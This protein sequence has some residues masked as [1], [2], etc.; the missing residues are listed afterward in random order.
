MQYPRLA[1]FAAPAAPRAEFWRTLLGLI[2]IGLLYLA[3]VYGLMGLL[4][5]WLA[6]LTFARVINAMAQ[7]SSPLGLVMLLASFAPLGIAVIFVA[8]SLHARSAGSLFGE[9]AGW[10]FLRVVMPLLGLVLLLTPLQLMDPDVGRATPLG[11]VLLWLPLAL[12]L[13]LVQ[14]T[15][16]ELIFRGYLLQQIAAR[17]SNPIGWMLLPSAL[18]GA[19]HFSPADFGANAIW[20][21][22][23][24]FVFGCL[25]A[26]LTARSGNLGAALAM[27]FT[28]NLS[29]MLLVGLYGNLDGLSLYTLVINTRDAGALGPYLAVDFLAMVIGW[30]AARL[31]LRL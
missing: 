26:D 3:A 6:P 10:D 12:P 2:G 19:L 5:D 22:L 15:A 13:L 16:E 31:M 9:G 4:S 1:R 11:R 28:T 30:L 7:G 29:S 25:A 23:W 18:F 21:V 8:R 24:A 14:I 17:T 20:P 27:H